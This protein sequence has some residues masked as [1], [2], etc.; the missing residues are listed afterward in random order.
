MSSVSNNLI[1]RTNLAVAICVHLLPSIK[2]MWS[3][4]L[5]FSGLLN[6]LLVRSRHSQLKSTAIKLYCV[7]VKCLLILLSWKD[8]FKSHLNVNFIDAYFLTAQYLMSACVEANE[9]IL[10]NIDQAFSNTSSGRLLG[11]PAGDAEEPRLIQ[12]R[13]EAF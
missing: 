9:G 13:M 8:N 7:N 5:F 11:A 1:V 3:E 4:E 10:W 6:A 12:G 2:T